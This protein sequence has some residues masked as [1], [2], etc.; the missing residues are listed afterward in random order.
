MTVVA[1]H[2]RV[3]AL[4]SYACR[5]LRKATWA[6]HRSWVL[7]P[8]EALESLDSLLWT[9]V[10]QDFVAHVIDRPDTQLQVARSAVVLSERMP[11][12]AGGRSLLLN[13][14][15]HV[16]QGYERFD[17]LIELVCD[18]EADKVAARARWRHYRQAGLVI[19]QHDVAHLAA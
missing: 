15:P 17:R 4:P 14:Q 12:E 16:P 9:L 5:L 18:E 1:F 19:E 3:P 13:L 8:P 6:G 2:F 7:G 10:P 11:P